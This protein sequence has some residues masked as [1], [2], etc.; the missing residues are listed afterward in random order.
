MEKVYIFKS[1]TKKVRALVA[2]ALVTLLAVGNV[3]AET[4]TYVF[5]E[6]YENGAELGDGVI[7][8][9]LS[10]TSSKGSA[11]NTPKVYTEGSV[12]ARFYYHSSGN[13]NSMTINVADGYVITGIELA[14]V[15]NYTPTVGY[16]ADG[17]DAATVAVE[18]GVYTISGLAAAESLKFYN[19]N[20]S[21][22]QLRI[23]SITI[24][25]LVEGST[26]VVFVNK[27]TFSLPGGTYYTA[28]TVALTCAT[29]GALIYCSI[30]DGEPVLYNSPL[31][32]NETST[33]KAYAV[34]GETQSAEAT[35]TYTFITP[36]ALNNIAAFKAAPN[37]ESVIYK[38]NT[39]VTYNFK[40]NGNMYV[41]DTSA[42][43]L[44]YDHSVIT[45]TYNPG[46]VISGGLIGTRKVYNGLVEMIPVANPA[47]GV[48]GTPILPVVVTMDEIL[49]NPE[50]FMSKLV[51]V[52]NCRLSDKEFK[53]TG[54]AEYAEIYQGGDTMQIRNAFK[55][56]AKTFTADQIAKI[57]GFVGYFKNSSSEAYQIYPRSLD[58][59]EFVETELPLTFDFESENA[60]TLVNGENVNKWYIGQAQGFDNSKLFVSSSNG[61][62][63]K[64]DIT[65]AAVSHAWRYVTMPE[66]DVVLSFDYKVTGEANNDY[67]Q[68]SLLDADAEVVAGTLP[69]DYIVRLQGE[70]E[71]KHYEITLPASYAGAKKLMFTWKNDGSAGNQTPAAVDNIELKSTCTA[72]SGLTA[73]VENHTATITWTAPEGQDAWTVEYKPADNSVWS[74]VN[75]TE[76]TA[77]LENLGSNT[78]YD[79][80]VK[81][82]CGN[83]SSL[84][85]TANFAVPCDDLTSEEMDITIG[86]GTTKTYYAPTAAYWKNGWVQMIYPASN[87]ESAGYINSI[88]WN[89]NTSS[90]YPYT[91][92]KIYMG[93][94]SASSHS[95]TNQWLAL[96]D[97]TL[98][99][100]AN[101]GTLGTATGWETFELLSPYY[102]NG[103]DNLVVVVSRKSDNYS[104]Y[105]FGYNSTFNSNSVI[106][107]SNDSDASYAEHP[108]S[109]SGT[110][111]GNLPN[112]K[113][114]Y[115]G[116]VCGDAVCE[117][118]AN[119][120]VSD[121]ATHSA[122]LVWEGEAETYKV[123]YKAESEEEWTVVETNNTEYTLT[124]LADNTIYNVRV[125]A[126]CGETGVSGEAA[127]SFT[128]VAECIV[129]TGLAVAHDVAATTITWT[130]VAGVEAY[131]VQ[132]GVNGST[133]V[134]TVVVENASTLQLIGL[135]ENTTY[136]A[137]VR[138]L[139]GE[140]SASE[141]TTAITFN[142]PTICTAPTQIAA[143]DIKT[144]SAKL[145]WAE[146]DASSWTVEY[147][148][149]GFTLGEGTTVTTNTNTVNITGLTPTTNYDV[150][151]KGNCN[152][153]LSPWSSKATF[154]T[155][156]APITITA[157][158]PWFEDFEGYAGSGEKSFSTCWTTPVKSSS[159]APFVYCNYSYSAHSGVNSAELKGTTNQENVLVLPAFTN[160]INTLQLSFYANT[161]ASS[162]ANAGTFE[163]GYVTDA[164]DGSTFVALQT[165]TP[166]SAMLNRSNSVFQGPFDYS[167]VAAQGARMAIHFKS[168]YGSYSATSWNLDDFTVSI[169][170]NCQEP[171]NLTTTEVGSE[172]ATVAWTSVGDEETWQI[173][174]GAQGFELGSGTIVE[175]NTTTF[176]I[177]NLQTGTAYDVY[178]N[179]LCGP[180]NESEW[181]GPVTF[182]PSIKC[183]YKLVLKDS[184]GDSWNG[185]K[186]TVTQNG[187]SQVFQMDGSSSNKIYEQTFYAHLLNGVD[188]TFTYT[189][190][191]YAGENSFEI[192][193]D[194]DN[195]VWS[196]STGTGNNGANHTVTP[197]C[198]GDTPEQQEC[199]YTIVLGD[200]YGDGWTGSYSG[201]AVGS[202]TIKQN[203]TTVATYGMEDGYSETHTLSL[204]D[205]TETEIILMPDYYGDEMSVKITD[206]S[207]NVIWEIEEGELDG[208]EPNPDPVTFTFTTNCGDGPATCVKPENL[209]VE[210]VTGS[211]ADLSWTG[212]TITNYEVSYKVA[213]DAE[214]TTVTTTGITYQLTG[215]TTNKTYVARVKAV[216][217]VENTYTNEVMFFATDGVACQDVEI[218]TTTMQTTQ[219]LPVYSYY[220]NS[221]SQQIYTSAAVGESGNITKIA[222]NYQP[223]SP[224]AKKP[225][226]KIYMSQTDKTS[227]S[228]STDWITENLVEVYSGPFNCVQGWNEFE[229]STPFAYDDTKNVVV[230]LSQESSWETGKVFYGT[231]T[232]ENVAIYWG[233]DYSSWST[234][235]SGTLS[236]THSN[237]KFTV[238]PAEGGITDVSLTS[239]E[240]IPNSCDLSNVPVTINYKNLGTVE[241]TALEAYYK[242]SD[243]S[244]THETITLSEPLANG[245]SAAYT[246]TTLANMPD[247]SNLTAWIEMVG[248]GNFGN[249]IATSNT[250]SIIEP[251]DVPFVEP[252]TNNN[253]IWTIVD[254]NDD[255]VKFAIT[256]GKATYTYNDLKNA[257]D[258]LISSCLY[259]PAGRYE[260]AYDYNAANAN[261]VENFGVYYGTKT[262]TDYN[263]GEAVAEHTFSNASAVTA[264]NQ[265]EIAQS[266]IY[267]FGIKAESAAGNMGFSIDNF[268]IK[269]LVRVTA[270]YADNGT[271]T[272][273]GVFYTPADEPVTIT[274]VPDAGYHVNAIYKNTRL[275][276]GANGDNAAIEY[277][278]FTPNNYDNVYVTFA[279]NSYEINATVQNLYVTEYNDNAP[280]ATYTPSHET[281]AH[282]ATHTGVITVA[283]YY[284]IH[285]VVVNGLNVTSDLVQ[286]GDNQY[287][288]TL[289]PIAESKNINVTAALDS[290]KITYVVNGGQGTINN[291]FVVDENTELPATYTV[292]LKGY[293]DLLSTIVP[294]PG[295]HVESIK[296]D[297]IEHNIIEVY[298]F[299]KLIGN[300]LVEVVFA[301][302]IYN[303]T[304]NAY[305]AGTVTPGM[306]FEYNPALVYAFKA[307]P[308]TG[309]HI[310]SV[311]RNG[312][313][314]PVADPEAEFTDTL[315]NIL[316]DYNYEVMFASNTYTV[317]ATA[318]GNGTIT[319]PGVTSYNYDE[320]VTY[321]A[322]AADGSYISS[323]VVD[324]VETTYTQADAVSSYSKAFEG[325]N[326]NHTIV[327]TFAPY[328]YTITVNAGENGTIAPG[329]ST[330][331]Y[332]ETPAFTI[333]P[334]AGY[335]IVDVAVDGVS[336]GAVSTYTFLPL[337]G[338]HTIAATFAAYQ[339]TI[340]A[341]A[342]NGGT[343]TSAGVT[344]MTYGGNKTYT[345]SPAEGYHI[346]N[347]YVDGVSVGAVSTY[348]FTNVT[349]N[350]VIHAAFA[351]NTYTITVNQPANGTI[352]PAG[353][354]TVQNGETPSFVITPNVGYSVSQITVN[355]SN[356]I[357][358]ATNVNDVYT[359]TFPAVTGNKTITATMQKKTFTITASAGANGQISNAGNST[360]E[361]GA[362]KTYTITP[363]AG[364]E[365]DNVVVDGMNMGSV[366]AYTFT[367]VVN[368]HTISVTFKYADCV[369]PTNLQTSHIDSTS[370]VLYWYH[371]NAESFDIQYKTLNGTFNSISSV[372]GSSYTLMGLTPNTTYLW[373]I[374]A[375]C[376]AG[377]HSDWSNLVVFT[378]TR[379]SVE[380]GIDD[381]DQSLIKVYADRQNIHIMNTSDL[382]ANGVNVYDMY[383]K[384]LYHGAL[385]ADH[386][387]INMNVAAGTYIVNIATEKGIFNYKV[388]IIR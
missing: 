220:N 159:N 274:I 354:I 49:A 223:S 310:A 221:Y 22:T 385:N 315:R 188:A 62:T 243:G 19:A 247:N 169:I 307:T 160:D 167:A 255:N 165:I 288:L 207:G 256:G 70:N 319:Y 40:A 78:T 106:Y 263:W 214:W 211:S 127:A 238:C 301:K 66:S 41:Q 371:P 292:T 108:G 273:E 96:D 316:S 340:T 113:V 323:V 298:S 157:A 205:A 325:M 68:V 232:T 82:N 3:F 35:A 229:L 373:Q 321:T 50:A 203:G 107:R 252:F 45:N 146:G 206:A 10:F 305:G 14:A 155:D 75:V 61:L 359:Y 250:V 139:C 196:L 47:T 317:T 334:N 60:W 125:S 63:N 134:N 379:P 344:N 352:S 347:V 219:F 23:S 297:G 281:L 130:P 375:N 69:T 89:V 355:T 54:S 151:V 192:F 286:T 199:E 345:I 224:I 277:Y 87:F 58:D 185:G 377:N 267:Y 336:V 326:G 156:C 32:L 260:V 215:L 269:P 338:S 53:T 257:N 79:V 209:V 46:D 234:S 55:T 303:I 72:V 312:V 299:E 21:N 201:A 110:Y 378:T 241:V 116:Y 182:I 117:A 291:T 86:T 101:N 25:Y 158:A 152:G 175:V 304:T 24:T 153:F 105:S 118:P 149:A 236:K 296:I 95:S 226:V 300:H 109:F 363:N 184:Y 210:N 275:V 388:T 170:P 204:S 369:V 166:T 137:T 278:T 293:S 193:D 65:K 128:T 351:A 76:A 248:D 85:T 322:T 227:F 28:Q 6:H 244:I 341:S 168:S 179:A 161:T 7:N 43:L 228:N 154:S 2:M 132:Y 270:S 254:D 74:A 144:T 126:D 174:Y 217:D 235:S 357:N 268:S 122:K 56:I 42:G 104:S 362:T 365:V 240:N 183:T 17:G 218:G 51:T 289:S 384:L 38:I 187:T 295:Y 119:V 136:K 302:N 80:R 171:M 361:Y 271:G 324:G 67:L 173:Q 358:N 360:V 71:Y 9:I 249:N 282:G 283:P 135:T 381:F 320:D 259:I 189:S 1:L 266:G 265:I 335:G 364:Y 279:S 8:D 374:R 148:V 290:A 368:N 330:Y 245:E 200:Y 26:P 314:M 213:T 328:A 83:V 230:T 111:S 34:L 150:Y 81:A 178:V 20:T 343:I 349:A 33:V 337:N 280:G 142:R 342:G 327:V 208:Y 246:F 329:T 239:I 212:D 15:G 141:W 331:S 222:F 332:N 202:L 225:N 313:E 198:G 370:A 181:I 262:G 163:V 115:L 242:L 97:L 380:V 233:N 140:E 237:I 5:A 36:T 287:K 73:T 64:Y 162:V 13:G 309:N 333:T 120:V 99:Y 348:S 123:A 164:E 285:S 145:T 186:L 18:G 100:E 12:G 258:W 216:C 129:P 143:S 367:N 180:G 387:I 90:S 103:E 194:E 94:T 27:P 176:K 272:P 264:K 57:T 147:G 276:R 4:V 197:N 131:E 346:D 93:T 114:D 339:Y 77:T 382:K 353:V 52:A 172:D 261:F 253:N 84:Y 251:K 190:G 98:V 16:V 39:D 44:I 133:D 318:I 177:E 112:M 356:V 91:N 195:L 88:A 308:T 372:S 59:I 48:A 294:A 30:N 37:D 191:S 124:E 231:L 350:H 311:L 11:S 383:G 366:T 121:V 31:L 102:Y 386:E 138:A 306:T 29:E 284:H 376:A 92:L